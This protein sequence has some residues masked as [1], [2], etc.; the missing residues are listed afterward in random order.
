V[1][2]LYARATETLRVV[3]RM[4]QGLGAVLRNGKRAILAV[5]AHVGGAAVR[6]GVSVASKGDGLGIDHKVREPLVHLLEALLR[7]GLMRRVRRTVGRDI[8]RHQRHGIQ[9]LVCRV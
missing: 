5:A 4:C 2:V 8:L 3:R 7:A 9:C 6:G 1:C